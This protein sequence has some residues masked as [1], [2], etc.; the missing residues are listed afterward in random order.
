MSYR[1]AM[2]GLFRM[3]SIV[4]DFRVPSGAPTNARWIKATMAALDLPGNSSGYMRPPY[5][6]PSATDIATLRQALTALDLPSLET[7]ASTWATEM[8]G[9]SA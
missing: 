7:A 1:K 9:A 2:Q 8:D 5:L 3:N 6:P 4:R